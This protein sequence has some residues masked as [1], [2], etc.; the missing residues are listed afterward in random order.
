[1]GALDS[2][3]KNVFTHNFDE[4]VSESASTLST[5][6]NTWKDSPILVSVCIG[7]ASLNNKIECNCVVIYYL[8]CI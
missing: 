5:E 8:Y 3:M 4:R 7:S 2:Q 1:M 6:H